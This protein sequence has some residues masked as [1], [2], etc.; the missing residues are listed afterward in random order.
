MPGFDVTIGH[1]TLVPN[2]FWG[3]ALLPLCVFGL[4]LFWPRIEK[5]RTGDRGLHNL[6]DAPSD[7][8]W[9]TALGVAFLALLGVVLLAGAADRLFV[10]F[11]IPYPA[12]VWVFRVA[13]FVLPVACFLVTR[14]LCQE[15][16]A[17][18]SS[19][20]PGETPA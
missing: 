11:G 8:A 14:R 10:S 1:Y 9:R 18:R 12:L 20:A 13:F 7:A 5:W 19:A 17:E 6:L 3:G 4:L 15:I 16:A 2:A